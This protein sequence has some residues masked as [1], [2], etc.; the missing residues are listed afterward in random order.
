MQLWR[1]A[2]G[3]LE[4]DGYRDIYRKYGQFLAQKKGTL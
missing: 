3:L 2:P 1:A 4:I